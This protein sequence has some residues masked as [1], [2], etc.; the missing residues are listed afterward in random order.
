MKS[1]T[2]LVTIAPGAVLDFHLIHLR[3]SA[4]GVRPVRVQVVLAEIEALR[5]DTVQAPVLE[6]PQRQRVPEKRSA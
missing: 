1:V 6:F 2:L 3:L 5:F 4:M